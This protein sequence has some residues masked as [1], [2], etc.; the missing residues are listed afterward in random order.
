MKKAI[1]IFVFLFPLM[2]EAQSG[3]VFSCFSLL[4]GQQYHRGKTPFSD[5]ELQYD[6]F[7][8]SCLTKPTYYGFAVNCNPVS[9]QTM[10]GTTA[11][12]NPGKFIIM[13]SRS[14]VLY[15]YVFGQGYFKSSGTYLPLKNE[16]KQIDNCGIIPG[17][18]ITGNIFEKNMLNIRTHLMLGYSIPL[19]KIKN[20]TG[21]TIGLKVGIGI[22]IKSIKKNHDKKTKSSI[23]SQPVS[24]P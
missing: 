7:H 18:G 24:Q 15:P 22:N 6:H 21:I 11:S 1:I 3:R 4:I 9:G 14:N 19:G 8:K 17:I 16:I 12:W 13:I 10:I 5:I 23:Q 2:A 20:D